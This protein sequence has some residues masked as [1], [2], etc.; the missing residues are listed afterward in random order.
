[1]RLVLVLGFMTVAA[2]VPAA[3]LRAQ[4][5]SSDGVTEIAPGVR[6]IDGSKVKAL[7]VSV[8]AIAKQIETDN[9]YSEMKK[10]L[11]SGGIDAP[12]P[13]GTTTYMYKIHDTDTATDKV[14][15]LFVAKGRIV[16]HMVS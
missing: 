4:S 1:M 3:S 11:K 14:L 12:G 6:Q 5:A 15:I 8:L 10:F 9:R 7:E 13:S 16:E 2:L